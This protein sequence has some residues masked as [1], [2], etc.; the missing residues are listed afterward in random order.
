MSNV[1]DTPSGGK[2]EPTR[3][4]EI[5]RSGAIVPRALTKH[6]EAA[7]RGPLPHSGTGPNGSDDPVEFF[8]DYAAA[9]AHAKRQAVIVLD[10]AAYDEIVRLCQAGIS[11]RI[12]AWARGEIA[13]DQI[14][15]TETH[16]AMQLL[17]AQGP[18]S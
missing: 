8:D 3:Y 13:R 11:A 1:S 6:L 2:R 17:H 10:G 12:M 5:D 18:V 7:E 9:E 16:R 14:H 15:G 4:L